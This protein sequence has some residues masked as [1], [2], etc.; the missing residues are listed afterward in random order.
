MLSCASG[1]VA[2]WSPAGKELT[3]WGSFVMSFLSLILSHWYP[4]SGGVLDCIDS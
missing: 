2:L 3:S 4:G 1:F